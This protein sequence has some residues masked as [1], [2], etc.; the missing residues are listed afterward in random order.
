MKITTLFL[1]I[2]IA[3]FLVQCKVEYDNIIISDCKKSVPVPIGFVLIKAGS[4][5]TGNT[6]SYLGYVD[7]TPIHQVTITSDFFIAKYEVTQKQY[8]S[9]MGSNPSYFKGEEQPV[10]TVTWIN[11]IYYCNKLSER[12]GLIKCYTINGTNVKCDWIANGYRLPTEAEWEY[13]CKAGTSNDFYNGFL[14]NEYCFPLDSCLDEIG[15]Y[16][17]N[18]G[19]STHDVGLKLPNAFGLYDM[20]GNVWEYCWDWYGNYDEKVA[21]DP[22]GADTG[23]GRVIRGGA[24]IDHTKNCRSSVRYADFPTDYEKFKNKYGF[25]LV[26]RP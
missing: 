17:G 25:R 7:E 22:Q 11:A 19:S 18:Y 21:Y 12:D 1:I 23:Q 24:W 15:W 13:A 4:F 2:F 16:C 10:E 9:I 26:R 8:E 6:G 5:R 20:H 14:T 3:S